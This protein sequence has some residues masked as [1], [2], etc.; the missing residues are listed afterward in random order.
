MSQCATVLIKCVVFGYVYMRVTPSDREDHQF[1]NTS[2]TTR[3]V[4][5]ERFIA[6]L[7]ILSSIQVLDWYRK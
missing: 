2:D 4:R 3:D 7:S 1:V 6:L 5:I